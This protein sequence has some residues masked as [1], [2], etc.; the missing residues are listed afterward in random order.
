MHP[1]HSK[2]ELFPRYE[3]LEDLPAAECASQ[4][5]EDVEEEAAVK[6]RAKRWQ[7]RTEPC[8]AEMEAGYFAPFGRIGL[9]RD[10]LV[11]AMSLARATAD[12]H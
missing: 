12:A 4:S 9:F 2:A 10:L 7:R 1:A 3:P 8:E 11:V 6:A 5:A